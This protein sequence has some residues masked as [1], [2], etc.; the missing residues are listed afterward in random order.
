LGTNV[1]ANLITF[2]VDIGTD[3]KLT[4]NLNVVNPYH[5]I[6]VLDTDLPEHP[7]IDYY[8]NMIRAI[9]AVLEPLQRNISD[10]YTITGGTE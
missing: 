9:I 1:T 4:T 8:D 2:T 7:M 3:G 5:V 6:N 10:E